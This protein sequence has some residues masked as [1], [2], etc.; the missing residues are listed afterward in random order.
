MASLFPLH[1]VL[2][3]PRE[4]VEVRIRVG[5]GRAHLGY[6]QPSTSNPVRSLFLSLSRSL[7]PLTH[8]IG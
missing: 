1:A 8:R 7:R 4:R 6:T 2:A 5:S 3:R